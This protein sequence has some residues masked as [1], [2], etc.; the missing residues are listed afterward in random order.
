[1]SVPRRTVSPPEYIDVPSLRVVGAIGWIDYLG[2]NRYRV[3]SR[4]LVH[5]LDDY[6]I[7]STHYD[8]YLGESIRRNVDS[9]SQ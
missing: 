6:S 8:L 9:R 2:H 1:M 4:V 5:Y 7:V 3:S